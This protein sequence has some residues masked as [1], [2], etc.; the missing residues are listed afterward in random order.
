MAMTDQTIENQNAE[1]LCSNVG[2]AVEPLT[3]WI[4][5]D[6]DGADLSKPLTNKEF[7]AIHGAWL[8]HQVL[9]FRNQDLSDA[10]LVR[11][12]GL[13]GEL[14][15]YTHPNPLE[16]DPYPEIFIVSNITENGQPIGQLGN[17]A[18][19]WH[20]DMSYIEIPPK[21]STIYAIEAPSE[22]GET[23]FLNMYHAY[24]S[25]DEELR[26]KVDG[27]HLNQDDGYAADG[28]LRPGLD[29]ELYADVT[30]APGP[31][32]P[33]VRTHPETQR[34]CLY[35]GKRQ[36]AY[37]KDFDLDESNA[38]LDALW[39]HAIREEFAWF[40]IWQPGDFLMWDNRCTMHMRREFDDSSRRILHRTQ[41][42]D[43]QPPS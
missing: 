25:L 13:F 20:T 9:R 43:T 42:K 16:E 28:L 33:I 38:V 34:K 29:P 36:R 24:E 32:H 40:N 7:E 5:A 15:S 22:G 27:A 14:D 26:R 2:I 6:V 41:V 30:T 21:M 3:E 10:D 8:Q 17:Y 11:F 12:G 39:S 23:G 4:G 37:I 18:V 35:L 31:I 19:K 1:D